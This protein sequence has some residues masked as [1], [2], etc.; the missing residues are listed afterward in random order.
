M[1]VKYVLTQLNRYFKK[2]LFKIYLKT[3]PLYIIAYGLILVAVY[4]IPPGEYWKS[5]VIFLGF[6]T[7]FFDQMAKKITAIT[8]YNRELES[9]YRYIIQ[10]TSI[11]SLKS[12]IDFIFLSILQSIRVLLYNV[13]PLGILADIY[14]YNTTFPSIIYDKGIITSL[15]DAKSAISNVYSDGSTIKSYIKYNKLLL[16]LRIIMNFCILFIFTFIFSIIFK[17]ISGEFAQQIPGE[18]VYKFINFTSILFGVACILY[19]YINYKNLL[20]NICA[21][22]QKLA[23]N[24]ANTYYVNDYYEKSQEDHNNN[25]YYQENDQQYYDY[26]QQYYANDQG[27]YNNQEYYNNNQQY[28][29]NNQYYNNDQYNN[30]NS[31]YY[32]YNDYI[33][34]G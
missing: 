16:I 7:I 9:D 6:F 20:W 34:K 33:D 31:Q 5:L 18:F 32:D 23:Y 10:N 25:Y 26:N 24:I 2:D 29:N 1:E 15:I 8:L 21:F 13:L 22:D 19:P 17:E 3:L 11:V 14:T 30:E 4:F 27:Y 12:V 28:Y